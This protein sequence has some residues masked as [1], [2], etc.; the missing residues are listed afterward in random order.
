MLC[1]HCGADNGDDDRF[2][3]RCQARMPSLPPRAVVQPA[4]PLM[5]S[6]RDVVEDYQAG[7]MDVAELEATLAVALEKME[8]ARDQFAAEHGDAAQTLEAMKALVE[9]VLEMA[10]TREAGSEEPLRRGLRMAEVA[11]ARL[12]ESLRGEPGEVV[13]FHYVSRIIP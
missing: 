4:T 8:A 12:A 7:C 5:R 6:L 10:R 1:L 3:C 2:C 9:A 11:D 13:S